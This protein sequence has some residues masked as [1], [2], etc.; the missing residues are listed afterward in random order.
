VDGIAAAILKR[1]TVLLT[2]RARLLSLM[3]LGL[4]LLTAGAAYAIDCKTTLSAGQ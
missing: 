4:W 2:F 3:I 1:S